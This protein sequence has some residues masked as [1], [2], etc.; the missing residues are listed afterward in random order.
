M[1][2]LCRSKTSYWLSFIGT[3]ATMWKLNSYMINKWLVY[4]N[5][6]VTVWNPE[7]GVLYVTEVFTPQQNP[8][9]PAMF[10]TAL[11]SLRFA[12]SRFWMFFVVT[13]THH[14]EMYAFSIYF[15]LFNG[16]LRNY[17]L[18][19]RKHVC[20]EFGVLHLRTFVKISTCRLRNDWRVWFPG[21]SLKAAILLLNLSLTL[22]WCTC[23]NPVFVD[24]IC[25]LLVH[26]PF[27]TNFT[28]I[29]HLVSHCK[30]TLWLFTPLSGL[31]WQCP[32][33]FP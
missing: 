23:H 28:R 25:P 9:S 26:L 4:T 14:E 29:L 33:S 19:V 22:A 1:Q 8:S 10:E 12:I 21:S 18:L 5:I 32:Q 11:L 6:L 24:S 13:C 3:D 16:F 2:Y 15:A 27:C 30:W 31:R 7:S 17:F 20:S